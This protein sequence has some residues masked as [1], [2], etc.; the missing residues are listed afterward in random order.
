[1]INNCVAWFSQ[2]AGKTIGAF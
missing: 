1:L 2:A